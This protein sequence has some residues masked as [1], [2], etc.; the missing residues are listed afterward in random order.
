MPR[1]EPVRS[2]QP[3]VPFLEPPHTPRSSTI[4]PNFAPFCSPW[5]TSKSASLRRRSPGGDSRASAY[6]LVQPPEGA[7]LGLVELE[8]VG[9]MA[10][11]PTFLR[12]VKQK[13]MAAEVNAHVRVKVEHLVRQKLVY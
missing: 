11:H 9:R 7:R 2:G 8:I 10:P 12:W 4:P 3:P 6:R 13:W 1:C 5:N